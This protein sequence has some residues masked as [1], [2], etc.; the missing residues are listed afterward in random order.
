MFTLQTGEPQSN[1]VMGI[2]RPTGELRWL[3]I[4]S[5]P[6]I[7]EGDE[8]PTAVVTTFHDITDRR[9]L[10]ADLHATVSL[11]SKLT[12][13]VPGVVYQFFLAPDGKASIPYA[14]DHAWELMEL[15]P[16]D[17]RD[18]AQPFFDRVHPE[19]VQELKASIQHS[20]STLTNWHAEFRVVLPSNGKTV[21]VGGD[22][23][24][25]KTADGGILW[26]GI[27][28]DISDV[29]AH[30]EY[31]FRLGHVDDSTGL[32]N[33]RYLNETLDAT[34]REVAQEGGTG[35]FIQIDLDD[36]NQFNDAYGH[37]AGDQILV[38]LAQR[39]SEALAEE[40]FVGRLGG[41]EFAV[42]YRSACPT[43]EESR[44]SA[45]S[46]VNRIDELVSQPVS[47][48]HMVYTPRC[49]AGVALFSSA[50][51]RAGDVMREADTA[52]YRAKS[53]GRGRAVV[54]EEQ[55]FADTLKKL[56]LT[57]DLGKALEKG[58][59]QVHIQSQFDAKRRLMGGELLLRWRNTDDSW[60]SPA[61][62]I[63][64]AEET[65]LIHKFGDFVLRQAC[66]VLHG[67]P[68][69]VDLT[70][71][72]NVSAVQFMAADFVG[73]VT[74]IL[75]E[76]A[77][78][79]RMLIL[80]VTESLLIHDADAGRQKMQELSCL[81]LS[82]SIDDF[83]TGYS[84][85]AY[86]KNLPIAELKIDQS[87]VRGLA[88]D[89]GDVAIVKAV[90]AMAKY[91]NLRVV[92]EGVER[93]EQFDFLVTNGYQLLQGFLLARPVALDVWASELETLA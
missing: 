64:L 47:L 43:L 70:L 85:L 51:T 15:R 71:S 55:M 81:G 66:S 31:L 9:K 26:H 62:F 74:A 24:P 40:C 7:Y 78:E 57:Q 18:N 88:T 19:D 21:W 16:E 38:A 80:E 83:G 32:P 58:Q 84:S 25:E 75:S 59:I 33:R 87:F 13:R 53:E 49:S 68:P 72:V 6:V 45:L 28:R 39:L 20:A 23:Q 60:I 82:F 2:R 77:V 54:F 52:L 3:I 17:I 67:L 48:E 30:E 86:L 92:A 27:T 29:K 90:L 65:G 22:A 69:N 4:N 10:E 44:Q 42:L 37:V 35:V 8:R 50:E 12:Q 76:F 89:G 91:L 46:L 11:L 1:V 34:I 61:V 56:A 36:F 5:E 73:R 41:D 14:S 79:P 63:P 93:D